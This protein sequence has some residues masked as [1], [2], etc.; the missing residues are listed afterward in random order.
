M[1]DFPYPDDPWL[2]LFIQRLSH[3]APRLEPSVSIAELEAA[4]VREQQGMG[5]TEAMLNGTILQPV[6]RQPLSA[7][8]HWMAEFTDPV[9]D[10][11][12]L[13]RDPDAFPLRALTRRRQPGGV[14]DPTER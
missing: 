9:T 4:A 6:Y 3:S 1:D 10:G 5:T 2:R 14:Q 13:P 11:V 12:V 8:W 7:S